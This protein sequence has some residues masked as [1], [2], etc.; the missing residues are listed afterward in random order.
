MSPFLFLQREWPDVC[1][2]AGK[3]AV[4]VY[5]DSRNSRCGLSNVVFPF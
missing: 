5:P 4:A 1:E 3:T 2:A